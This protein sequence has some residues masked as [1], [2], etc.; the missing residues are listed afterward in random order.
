MRGPDRAGMD[1]S[2]DD[3]DG[4]KVTQSLFDVTIKR[5]LR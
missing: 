3:A 4:E 1:R 5:R 2:M